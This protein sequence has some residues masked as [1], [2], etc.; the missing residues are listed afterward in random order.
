M[1]LY[2]HLTEKLEKFGCDNDIINWYTCGPTVH[3]TVHMGHARTFSIFDSLRKY[4]TKMG[5]VVNYGMNITDIDDKINKIVMEKYIKSDNPEKNIMEMYYEF[6][7]KKTEEFWEVMGMLNISPPTIT[8]RVSEVI[9]DIKNFIQVLI[10]KSYAYESNGSV[11]F[12]TIKYTEIYGDCVLSNS[13]EDDM[14]V[15]IDYVSEKLDQKD[16]ALW[17]KS[18]DESAVGF[19]SVWGRGTP[20]WHIECS[21]MSTLMFGETVDLHTGGIDLR[22]PHHHNEVLQSNVYHDKCD[23]FKHFLYTGH[24]RMLTNMENEKMEPT[25]SFI[26]MSQSLG[27]FIT[28]TDYIKSHSANSLRLLFWMSPMDH[29][30]DITYEF[31]ERAILLDKRIDEFVSTLRFNLNILNKMS[32]KIES[33][34]NVI[35]IMNYIAQ[36]DNLLNKGFKINEAL[37]TFCSLITTTNDAISKKECDYVLLQKIYQ[38]VIGILYIIGYTV[39]EQYDCGDDKKFLDEILILR[40]MIRKEK[41]YKVS[42]YIRDEM[43]PKLGYVLQDTPDGEKINKLFYK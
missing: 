37:S 12:N 14:A 29:Q 36:I 4:L 38:Y 11:Y 34:E 9:E 43:I 42:D 8:I 32:L 2:N 21:V 33:K 31:M 40:N 6:V 39:K 41:M 18:K 16:F 22:F 10:D 3:N 13:T 35:L 25:K 1:D 27:N 24:V 19:E 26:K 5:K 15:K 23:V 7:N 30:M 17:K 20:G 28:V